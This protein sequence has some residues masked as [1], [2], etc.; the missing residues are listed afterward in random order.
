[1][2]SAACH[3]GLL[4]AAMGSCQGLGGWP[5]RVEPLAAVFMEPS[6]QGFRVQGWERMGGWAHFWL[7]KG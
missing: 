6:D 7:A 3:A 4:R 1:M 5:E 2:I